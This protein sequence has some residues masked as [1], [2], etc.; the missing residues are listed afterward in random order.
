MSAQGSSYREGGDEAW[1]RRQVLGS[2]LTI[3]G[4]VAY[5][6]SLFLKY[7]HNVSVWHLAT[8]HDH[9]LSIREPLI[10][11]ILAAVAVLLALAATTKDA[12]AL[13]VGQAIIGCYLFGQS[14][15]LGLPRYTGLEVGY[16]AGAVGGLAMAVGGVLALIGNLQRRRSRP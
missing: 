6:V 16:W 11:T 1:L 5:V 10:H 3:I 4:G 14:F 7:V 15:N 13:C 9:I 2:G 12:T 8:E